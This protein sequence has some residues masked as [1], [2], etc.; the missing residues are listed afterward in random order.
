MTEQELK[1]KKNKEQFDKVQAKRGKR[2]EESLPRAMSIPVVAFDLMQ[3]KRIT[4]LLTAFRSVLRKLSALDYLA[5]MASAKW[6][7]DRL[8]P[9]RATK[10]TLI[11]AV[12]GSHGKKYGYE[13]RNLFFLYW[14]EMQAEITMRNEKREE[15]ELAAAKKEVKEKGITIEAA[16]AKR[17]TVKTLLP[18]VDSRVWDAVSPSLLDVLNK[19]TFQRLNDGKPTYFDSFGLPFFHLDSTQRARMDY[20]D[21]DLLMFDLFLQAWLGLL[22]HLRQCFSVPRCTTDFAEGV[23]VPSIRIHR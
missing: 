14:K 3:Y 11:E 22:R 5:L 19:E 1:K 8:L 15:N 18:T 4:Q 10:K 12:G 21:Q 2:A 20:V 6:T 13:L 7:G 9:A 17:K 23:L 16:L